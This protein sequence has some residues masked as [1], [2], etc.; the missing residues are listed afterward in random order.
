MPQ[1]RL[2]EGGATPKHLGSS[3]SIDRR[4]PLP[5]LLGDILT[6]RRL[7]PD[8]L[9]RVN[10]ILEKAR[11]QLQELAGA[12]TELLFAARRRMVV[13]LT[14]DERSTPA[15]RN[16]LK[17]LKMREQNGLCPLCTKALPEK[18]AELDRHNAS[19]GYTAENTRLVHHECHIADQKRKRYL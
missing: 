18:Y 12:D 2:F 3:S 14:H 5:P 16:K 15:K 8:E 13:Q 19:A 9:D 7:A 4:Q 1:W 11:N 6:N 10:D 17:V